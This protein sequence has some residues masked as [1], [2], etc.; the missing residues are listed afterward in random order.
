MLDQKLRDSFKK[1]L[2]DE[3]KL[4]EAELAKLGKRNPSNPA[5]WVPAKRAEDDFGPDR[6][7]NA[8][9]I[10][11]MVEDSASMNELE[12]RLHNVLSAL[13]KMDTGAYGACEVDG[14]DIEL[15]RLD[16][17]PAASTCKAHMN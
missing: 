5:D 6:N 2:E 3:K 16:A 12:A 10:E 15:D 17:N 14:E 9:I 1:R 11:N 7:D 4:L 13:G 8:D